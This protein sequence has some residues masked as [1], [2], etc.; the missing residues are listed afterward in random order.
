[1]KTKLVLVLSG[2]IAAGA[3]YLLW[4]PATPPPIAPSV[5]TSERADLT[6]T[7]ELTPEST[8]HKTVVPANPPVM[9]RQATAQVQAQTDPAAV[10]AALLTQIQT[11]LAS[12]NLD[13]REIVFTN[14]LAALVQTDPLAAARFA[15]T[16]NLGDTHNLILHRVA[17]LWAATD[18][19]AALN[20]A[21]TLSDAGERDA[22]L[23]DVCLEVAATDPAEAVKTRSQFLTDTNP[24]SGLEALAQRWA[25]K[26]FP[27]ALE[28]ALTRA[29][30]EQRDQLIARLAFIQ[31]Q[32]SPIEA[33][34]LA[35]QNI[36]PGEAQTEA[37]MAVLHQWGLRDLPAAQQWVAQFPDGDLRTRAINELE[38]IAK[39]QTP[40]QSP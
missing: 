5:E 29:A 24:N 14:L 8:V 17:Q 36:P 26:D 15:E 32:T 4:K 21:A 30:G 34:T 19:A 23:T 13:D 28:W 33:G 6:P 2:I 25:E 10:A 9:R 35:V 7:V 18:A 39:Y 37:V 22:I 31:S 20:W 12:T 3:A 38:G 11:A 27:A 40:A 16:N 1:M